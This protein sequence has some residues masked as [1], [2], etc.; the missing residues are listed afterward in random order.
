MMFRASII[1]LVLLTVSA[2][3]CSSAPAPAAPAAQQAAP[4]A[5][6]AAAPGASTTR[7]AASGAPL[8]QRQPRPHSRHSSPR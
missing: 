8:P 2:F 3:A 7:A 5:A 6:P 1:A 4:A